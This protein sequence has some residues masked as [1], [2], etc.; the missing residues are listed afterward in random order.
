MGGTNRWHHHKRYSKWIAA[1]FGLVVATGS[2]PA[3]VGSEEFDR[4]VESSEQEIVGGTTAPRNQWSSVVAIDRTDVPG[5]V[6]CGGTLIAPGWVL[7]A[8]HCADGPVASY[9]V[10]ADR[11][12]LRTTAGRISTVR[13]MIR[14][15]NFNANTLDNDI[16]LFELTNAFPLPSVDVAGRY[17]MNGVVRGEN[18]TI[19]GWGS[20]A[21]GGLTSPTLQ[22]GQVPFVA[23]GAA[24]NS[25]TTDY[26]GITANQMCVGPL[27]GG[28][29]TCQGDSGGP[30]FVQRDGQWIQVGITSWG[31]G[32]ARARLPGIYTVVANYA[33]WIRAQ[34]TR[35]RVEYTRGDFDGDLRSDLII[36]TSAG[37][38][39]YFS[40]GNGTWRTPYSR[41][42]LPVGEV[43]YTP[44]DYNGDG[45]T[46]LVIT[47]RSGSYWY[48]SNGN[49]T[50]TVPYTRTDLP[51]G[52]VNY[53]AGTFNGD[54]RTDLVI[55]T[56]GGSYWYMSNGNGT[57]AVP[58]S[59]G[60]LPLGTVSYAPGD[61]NADGRTD[62]VIST[63]SGSHWYFNNGNASGWTVP[64]TRSDLPIGSVA[65]SPVDF[66]GDGRTDLVISTPSGSYWYQS[67][68]NGTWNVPYSRADLPLGKAKY[69]AGNFDAD[70]D[71]D[72]VITTE[73]GS[74]WY[75]SAGN[76]IFTTPYS[77]SDLPLG[78][79]KYTG[80]DFDADARSDLVISTL[81]GSFWYFSNGN[82]TWRQL[83]S[84]GDLP[85]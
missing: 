23:A 52:S 31:I 62:L 51:L 9:Q 71:G 40:N 61:F 4:D 77:R 36:T 85:L 14:H 5:N 57:W 20:M 25:P 59:R 37:S 41:A 83:Y 12:D 80:G 55:T 65:Y 68:G 33:D 81:S 67:V 1:G 27:A 60:D 79:V 49:G 3:C 10:I 48:F 2:L 6:Y 13:R 8:A 28:R 76:G 53:V 75:F 29:D 44:G 56:T 18:T 22:Q 63:A 45:K 21:E 66:S 47:T 42:D 15:P 32:C 7:T 58:Y 39:W 11:H 16:A 24:C 43:K 84:R 69:T 46:D 82:G 74:Y 78:H 50:W 73:S 30:V 26:T 19:V 17:E 54:A 38:F 35:N 72:L 64:Y 70:A 34:T